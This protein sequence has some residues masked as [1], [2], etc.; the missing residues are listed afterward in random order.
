MNEN[1]FT[2][3]FLPL[4]FMLVIFPFLF[5]NQGGLIAQE[6]KA[7]VKQ[8]PRIDELLKL[9]A[10]LSNEGEL[11]D[12]YKIQLHSGS[13]LTAERILKEYRN[14]IGLHKSQIVYE[15]PNYKIWI[16]NYRNRLEADRALLSIKK[17][18]PS[19]FIFKPERG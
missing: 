19:A 15:T 7:V 18:F 4:V 2:N 10:E 1:R 6:T 8:D 11:S 14:K 3:S 16:G 13:I 9:K 12:R 5:N 17:E